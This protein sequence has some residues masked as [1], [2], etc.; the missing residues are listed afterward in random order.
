MLSTNTRSRSLIES[1][2]YQDWVV[3]EQTEN[4]DCQKTLVIAIDTW[5][6]SSNFD[7]RIPETEAF[8]TSMRNL[9]A[10][11]CFSPHDTSIFN[12][13]PCRLRIKNSIVGIPATIPKRQPL[14]H[15]TRPVKISYSQGRVDETYTSVMNRKWISSPSITNDHQIHNGLTVDTSK[16]IISFDIEECIRYFAYLERPLENIIF[17]GKHLNWCLLNRP[18]GVEEWK[19]RGFQNLFIRRDSTITTNDPRSP[20]YCSQDEMDNIYFRYVESYW[21]KTF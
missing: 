1:G 18:I 6:G 12:T 11:I 3:V 9:G 17:C 7:K 2:E 10:V 8:L 5:N 16:D 19:R 4:I 20:P 13:H 15:V 14:K 21:A